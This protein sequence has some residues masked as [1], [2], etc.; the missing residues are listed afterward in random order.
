MRSLSTMRF[1]VD[2]WR[3]IG[4]RLYL[5]L[6]FAVFL[7]LMSSAVGVYYFE[8]S[9]DLNFRVRSESVPVLESSWTVAREVERLKALGNGLLSDPYS[10]SDNLKVESVGESLERIESNLA[11]VSGVNALAQDAD[12][13]H[14]ASFELASAIDRIS[15]NS[16]SLVDASTVAASLQSELNTVSPPDTTSQ[17]ALLV[18]ERAMRAE[19]ED[20]LAT[21]WNEFAALSS[22]GIDPALA[23]LVG[24]QGVFS[25]RGLQLGLRT[26]ADDLAADLDEASRATDEAVSGL[27]TKS[28]TESEGAIEA[29]VNSFDQGRVLLAVVSV[30]SVVAAILAAWLWVGNGVVQRLSHLSDRMRNMAR[31]D[32][33]T[34][35]PEIGRDEIGE[36]ADALEI[37]RKQALE[38][39]RL[40]LVEQL[41]RE[42]REV[43]A[44]LQR[45]QAR[46]VAQE[47]LAALG[48]LVS[49]VAHEISNPLNFV[50]NFAEGS[51][52][53]YSELAD[54]LESNRDNLSEEDIELFDEISEELTDSLNRVRSNGGRALAIVERM[55]GLGVV[56]GEPVPT[57]L[58][59][60]LQEAVRAGCNTFHSEWTDFVIEPDFDLEPILEPAILVEGDFGEA[61]VN[62]VSNACYSMR[63]KRNDLGD[64]YEPQLT[65]SSRL[66]DDMIEVRVRDNGFG[67]ADD[68]VGRIFNPFFSTRDG[69]AGA[70]LGL[71][72]AADVLR[73]VG[74]DL[75]VETQQGEYAEFTMSIPATVSKEQAAAAGD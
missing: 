14:A 51:L 53:L 54:M 47:K 37:F 58:N 36:L 38:V 39:Q 23:S 72:I 15:A 2:A 66:V 17:S 10:S 45:T 62:I 19:D 32:L 65:V 9:G 59:L 49:G 4:V 44:E 31:G 69:A 67:I 74:G 21:H 56:G 64:T 70:G 48:E 34:P 63:L 68:M 3:R 75:S 18:L 52:E 42:L 46:L 73:R 6:G 22:S 40:N 30:A 55:R 71:P 1:L 27:L 41:Y 24:D 43:N 61:V 20:A 12:A 5:A 7:T 8:R 16:A 13:A 35:V 57:D 26:R 29:A 33:E 50:T 28:R 60:V 25:V 11:R